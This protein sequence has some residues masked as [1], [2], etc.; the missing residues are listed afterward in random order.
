MNQQPPFEPMTQE[1][2]LRATQELAE[3][4]PDLA[5]IVTAI[6]PPPMWGRP[7]GFP[8]LIHIILE[9][10][11]SLAS[12]K[13]AFDRLQET[14][15]PLTPTSFLTLD[16]DQLKTIGFSRQK[17]RY[18]RLLAEAILAGE[19]DL[20][21]LAHLDDDTVLTEL[22]KIKG[23]GPWTAN[24][25]LL[26]VLRRPDAWATGDLALAVAAQKIKGLEARPTYPELDEM[27]L[28]WRPWRAVA[29]RLLWHYYLNGQG[30]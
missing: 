24:V 1:I 23:I 19:L 6:G 28:A 15:D 21:A 27:A 14:L 29:A 30:A 17:T 22:T 25:Y 2:L 18:G 8:T 26:M 16:D 10:Q 13:A 4:D 3:R 5:Y 7:Q 9:Q 11:V 20:P 12:A